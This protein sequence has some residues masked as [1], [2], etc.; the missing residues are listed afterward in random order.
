VSRK[1]II[2]CKKTSA[3]NLSLG[4]L[5]DTAFYMFCL[6]YVLHAADDHITHTL[7]AIA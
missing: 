4:C 3:K 2:S 6:G 7:P 1:E 5:A